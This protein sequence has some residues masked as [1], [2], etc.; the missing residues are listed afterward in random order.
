MQIPRHIIE[1][2][3]LAV[4]RNY[5]YWSQIMDN[6]LT[7]GLTD[8]LIHTREHCRRVLLYALML[9]WQRVGERDNALCVL[10][11]AAIFHD[12]RRQNDWL[13]VG[14]GARA[15]KYYLDFCSTHDIPCSVIAAGIIQYHD[16]ND[17]VGIKNL[18]ITCREE[19]ELAI[20]LYCIFKDADA[21]DRFRLGP[22]GLDSRF[23]RTKEAL[24]MA[25]FAKNLV[26]KTSC[27]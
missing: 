14:H 27:V 6:T 26:R 25:G 2:Q 23:L 24:G 11:Q 15:A 13:D 3:P 16:R 8:S 17:R 21:L 22:N 10:S 4:K 1:E 18:S 19:K 7:F 9:G 12:T 5:E 20:E